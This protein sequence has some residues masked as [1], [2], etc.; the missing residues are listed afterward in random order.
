M[1]TTIFIYMWYR[2]I[3]LSWIIKK[4]T[5]I[6][7]RFVFMLFG[8]LKELPFF[9]NVYSISLSRDFYKY[10]RYL[11]L[12]VIDCEIY[13]FYLLIFHSS[14]TSQIHIWK[15]V[16]WLQTFT[17]K[18]FFF[19]LFQTNFKHYKKVFKGYS[20]LKCFE[21]IQLVSNFLSLNIILIKF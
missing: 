15:I 4:T 6:F 8:Y 18:S 10:F 7:L 3:N 1:W 2:K 9:R 21:I 16:S 12:M 17:V 14:N 13:N 11:F 19:N 20:S 5:V